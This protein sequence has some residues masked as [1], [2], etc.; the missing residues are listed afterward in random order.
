MLNNVS[1]SRASSSVLAVVTKIMSIPLDFI[2]FIILDLWENQLLFDTKR[3][4][5]SAIE[6]VRVYAAEVTYTRK[7]QG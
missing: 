2:N 5:S 7:C 1:S 3:I 4:V 6:S